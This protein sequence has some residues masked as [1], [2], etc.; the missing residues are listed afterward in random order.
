[1]E[2]KAGEQKQEDQVASNGRIWGFSKADLPDTTA[3]L[4][5]WPIA[6]L[7]LG[8]DL[9]T[10]KAVFAWL[11]TKPGNMVQVIDGFV[12]LRTALNDGAAFNIAAG[13]QTLLVA[14]STIALIVIVGVFLFGKMRARVVQVAM[15]LFAAGVCGNLW[16]RAFNDGLVRDFIDVV[17][18]PGRHWPAFN[19]ADSMLCIAVALLVVATLFTDSSCRKHDPPRK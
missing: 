9:W 19:V 16:D 3:H 6:L 1:M 13:K 4:L 10:K 7:G 18:W 5:F 12:T 8:L 11:A 2:I 17:Y 14:V 15:G